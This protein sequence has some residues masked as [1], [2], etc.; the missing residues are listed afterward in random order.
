MGDLWCVYYLGIHSGPLSLASP[1]WVGAVS[2]SDGFSHH[3]RRNSEFCVTVGRTGLSRRKALAV[4][5][6]RPAGQRSGCVLAAV[7]NGLRSSY[8]V[9]RCIPFQ[10]VLASV[11]HIRC[12]VMLRHKLCSDVASADLA[13]LFGVCC[14]G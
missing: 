11:V 13:A 9:T 4:N 8:L 12:T 7:M 1:P 14:C 6:S 2:S 5:F 3:W 10:L